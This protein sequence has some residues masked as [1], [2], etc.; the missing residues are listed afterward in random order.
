MSTGRR[1]HPEP[2]MISVS[3]EG[4]MSALYGLGSDVGDIGSFY[5]DGTWL[6]VEF[7]AVEDNDVDNRA[8]CLRHD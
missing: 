7:V 5:L 4:G 8:L 6:F 3:V 2:S 1:V